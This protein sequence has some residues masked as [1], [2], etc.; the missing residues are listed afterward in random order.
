M[1]VMSD[2]SGPGVASLGLPYLT[3]YALAESGL[4][5]LARTWPAQEMRRPGCVWTHTLLIGFADLA[6]LATPSIVTQLFRRPTTNGS[7]ESYADDV[8]FES[9]ESTVDL[10]LSPAASFLIGKLAS[11]LYEHPGAQVWARRTDGK[12]VDDAVLRLWDQQWPR[13]KRSFRFCTLTSRDRSQEG[14]PFDL[15]LSPA[16]DSSPHL[17][18]S[19]ALDGFE[20]ISTSTDPWLKDLLEDARW[21]DGSSLRNFLRKLGSD[22]LVGREAMRLFCILHV[23][24]E[25]KSVVGLS[26]AVRCVESSPLL[27]NSELVKTIVAQAAITDLQLVEDHVFDFLIENFQLLPDATVRQHAPI[28]V[29]EL[30]QRNPVGLVTLGRECR[31]EVRMAIREGALSIPVSALAHQIQQVSGLAEGV[32]ELLP[33]IAQ[34]PLFWSSSQLSP[35]AAERIGVD[36]ANVAV[37]QAMILGLQEQGQIYSVLRA[38]GTIAVLAAVQNLVK[39]T[40]SDDQARLWLQYACDDK[41]A[42]AEFLSTTSSPSQT[43]LLMLAEIV[44]PDDI[45][46]EVGDDPWYLALRALV[47]VKFGLPIELQVFGFRRALGRRSQSAAGL[48]KLTFGPLH[49]TAVNDAFPPNVWRVLDNSLPWAPFG[50]EWDHALRLRRATARR[51]NDMQ[52]HAEDLVQLVSSDELF[53]QLLDEIWGLWGGSRY[54]RSVCDVLMASHGGRNLHCGNLL[55]KFVQGQPSLW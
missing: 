52:F 33:V 39:S 41:D 8:V 54:L 15:Q 16:S 30:W 1:L 6:A 5:A 31:N 44:H 50:H 25:A 27:S 40:N 21:A 22:M 35:Q 20:A 29:P 51:C 46:N 24:L 13:L 53:L 7:L 9:Q 38:A 19:S 26:D 23:A 47:D 55:K 4:Y 18:F 37:L 48:L 2:A 28:F 3:G 34:E 36:L 32:L 11:A 14:V 49:A 42:I 12:D 10:P 43:L 17:R 45:P